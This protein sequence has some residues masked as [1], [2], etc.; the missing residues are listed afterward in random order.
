MRDGGRLLMATGT[1]ERPGGGFAS[2]VVSDTGVGMRP[3][4]LRRA[5]EPF[6]TTKEV[7]SGTGLGLSIVYG[8]VQDAGG[9]VLLASEPDRGTRVEVYLPLVDEPETP[10]EGLP[11]VQAAARGR[12]LLVEDDEVV[13]SLAQRALEEAGYE[14]VAASDGEEAREILTRDRGAWDLVIT[15]LVMPRLGGRGLGRWIAAHRP[16]VPVLYTSGFPGEDA[17][18]Q[19]DGEEPPSFLAK[20]FTPE[21]LVRRV[22]GEVERVRS[23]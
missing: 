21:A 3:E 23:A 17:G 8:I 1:S 16:G 14:V 11:G 13:R 5:F 20:P 10:P 7:G 9:T 15:D 18:V 2:I 12:V 22:S 19:G 4:V 6:F